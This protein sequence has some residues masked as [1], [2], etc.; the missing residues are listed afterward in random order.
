MH[1]QAQATLFLLN[2]SWNLM[3][4]LGFEI[5]PRRR[6]IAR[7][8]VTPTHHS[9]HHTERDCNYAHF[10]A[11]LDTLFGSMH[12]EYFHRFLTGAPSRASQ[13]TDPQTQA[14]AA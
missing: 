14:Q 12:P 13:Q 10:F 7:I 11:F 2:T 9:M 1:P 8:F 3:Q 4:H 6:W 5:F